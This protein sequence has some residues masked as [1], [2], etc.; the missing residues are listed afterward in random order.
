MA[1]SIGTEV[2]TASL[3][4]VW[5]TLQQVHA[6]LSDRVESAL[7]VQRLIPLG[8]VEVLQMLRD[9]PDPTPVRVLW[10]AVGGSQ[11]GLSR[12]LTRMEV[13]G[14]TTRLVDPADAR[15]QLTCITAKG[16][17]ALK[18][19][20]AMV[21]STLAKS[22]AGELSTRDLNSLHRILTRLHQGP[23]VPSQRRPENGS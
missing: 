10:D 19:A 12:R 6:D 2:R 11:P 18:K 23:T 17:T 16:R 14:F 1:G 20:T 7:A 22:P 4:Q 15:A 21:T 5:V 9:R 13:A 8:F 3:E